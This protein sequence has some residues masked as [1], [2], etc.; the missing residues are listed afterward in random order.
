MEK[1]KKEQKDKEAAISPDLGLLGRKRPL[2][3]QKTKN[4]REQ[5][6]R[7][8]A[9]KPDQA[10]AQ[11]TA[12][13]V[14]Q[15][16]RENMRKKSAHHSKKQ[17]RLFPKILAIAV[18]LLLAFWG[19]GQYRFGKNKQITALTNNFKQSQAV[20]SGI[21]QRNQ[22][23]V[24][25]SEL[26][27]LQRYYQQ[28]PAAFRQMQRNLRNQG[29]A[30][31]MKLIKTGRNWYLF[32]EYGLQLAAYRLQV[33]TPQ[34][35]AR[36]LVNGQPL[37]FNQEGRQYVA[38]TMLLP[39]R[40]RLVL[41]WRDQRVKKQVDLFS[42]RKLQLKAGIKAKPKARKAKQTLN[43]SKEI[44]KTRGTLKQ[45]IYQA[46]ATPQPRNF[47]GGKSN[48]DYQTLQAMKKSW[49]KKTKV[50]IKI[51]SQRALANGRLINYQVIYRFPSGA[52]Q[53]MNYDNAL[54]V[55]KKHGWRLQRI[56]SGYL[57]DN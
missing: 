57:S 10:K 15:P 23:K 19:V 24:S 31:G 27:P 49:A 43:K 13:K 53:T 12:S 22:A 48:H 5:K 20:Y 21:Y 26:Q 55:K 2:P 17:K 3:G 25:V 50:K 29:H 39:G 30:R 28:N 32:P 4:K 52:R 37:S 33:Q 35:H 44:K 9:T 14:K 47:V 6:A 11:P 38:Q 7:P 46:F 45:V 56:G 18:I 54:A 40:Y 41:R 1:D 42:S 51:S 8:K 34:A 16:T 36:L